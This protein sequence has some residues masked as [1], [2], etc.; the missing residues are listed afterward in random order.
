MYL[1]LS[2]NGLTLPSGFNND[3]WHRV[4]DIE[5]PRHVDEQLQALPPRIVPRRQAI[6]LLLWL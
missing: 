6:K 3:L 2:G 4:K 5:C 1:Y